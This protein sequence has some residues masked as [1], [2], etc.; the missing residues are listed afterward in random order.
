M[1][2]S[3]DGLRLH[4][5][6]HHGD[7]TPGSS[8]YIYMRNLDALQSEL[9]AKGSHASIEGGPNPTMRVLSLWDP[10]GNRLR[11]A[12]ILASASDSPPRGYSVPA[13]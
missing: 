10:F 9:R 5:S 11:F 6:E 7:A 8:T 4:V 3:R 12:E 13:A 2:V 1:Q